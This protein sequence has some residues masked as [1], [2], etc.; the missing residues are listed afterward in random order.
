MNVS[1][2]APPASVSAPEAELKTE[3][4]PAPPVILTPVPAA[5]PG[6]ALNVK[7]PVK[8]DAS[9]SVISPL[10]AFVTVRF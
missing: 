1:L 3:S 2:P 4:L 9:T 8:A 5:T 6:A 7:L 10:V